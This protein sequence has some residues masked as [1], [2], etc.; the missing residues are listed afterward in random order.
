MP[1]LQAQINW[2]IKV[3]DGSYVGYLN[4]KFVKFI[5]FVLI[6]TIRIDYRA[7]ISVRS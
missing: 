6:E 1:F 7:M 3:A 5:H 2:A 4:I